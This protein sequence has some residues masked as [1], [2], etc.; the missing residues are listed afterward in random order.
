MTRSR[1]AGILRL[2]AVL[3]LVAALALSFG[4]TSDE[5][6]TLLLLDRSESVASDPAAV[7]RQQAWVRAAID[8]GRCGRPCRVIAFGGDAEFEGVDATAAAGRPGATTP[9]A[10]DRAPAAPDAAIPAPDATTPAP[11]ATDLAAALRLATGAL[12]DGGRAIV[13]SDGFA[14]DGD[15]P[16]A[17]ARAR[18]AKV[19]VDGVPLAGAAPGA[20][21]RPDAAVTRL[22]VP[23]PLRAG[24]ALTIQATVRSTVAGRATIRL[25]RDGAAAGSEPLT[26]R[27]GDNPLVLTYDAPPEGWHAYRLTVDLPGD[28]VPANDTAYATTR[29]APAPRAL[30]VGSAGALPT[31]LQNAGIAST[32]AAP[33]DINAATLAASDLVVLADLPARALSGAQQQALADAVRDDGLGLLVLGGEHSLSLGGWAGTPLDALLP[34]ASLR[35]GGVRR[36]RLALQLVLD[37]SSSMNDLAGGDQPKIAMAR[38]A[39]R[40][41]LRLTARDENELGIVTFDAAAR[42]LVP[43]Q[44]TTTANAG[45][46]GEL[47]DRLDAD[48]GTNVL[49]GLER[50]VAQLERSSAPVKHLLLLSDGVSE[51]ADYAPLLRRMRADRI[52]LSTVALGQDAD[53]ELMRRLARSAGGRF[54]A[55]PDAR[56]LPQVFAQEARRSAP[57][58]AARGELPVRETAA[59]PL[60]A[61]LQQGAT[62]PPVRGTVL[63]RLRPD[64]LA[65]LSA[66]VNGVTAPLLAQG[67]AGLGRVVVWTPGAGAWA[68]DWPATAPRLLP[69]AARWSAKPVATPPLT[70]LLDGDRLVVDPLA[71]SG[72]PLDL[73]TVTATVRAPDGSTRTLTLPQ[74][75]PS[76]YAA[77]LAA[78]GAASA[79]D[80]ATSAGDGTTSAG[81]SESSAE[82]GAASGEDAHPAP[83]VYAVATGDGSQA[84]DAYL[85]VQYAA[86]LAPQPADA[87]QLGELASAGGGSLLDPADP[88][89]ALA[90]DPG[91]PAWRWL[92][93]AAIALL[94]AAVAAPRLPR[95]AQARSRRR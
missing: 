24:D 82:D 11:D 37:R 71:T 61:S 10:T 6:P 26:L 30:I 53:A 21:A 51:P 42:D 92:V 15:A 88:H 85:P 7:A 12:P 66:T 89:T 56:R 34:V 65:P 67:Q 13:L 48:G 54:H 38:A 32:A 55:V 39:A 64:A 40:S 73:A 31:Q 58:V 16:A 86:E 3:A 90:P 36:R 33:Q 83:G 27:R 46:I 28:A 60:L 93:A 5:T 4:D 59:S 74:V 50:G 49:R 87:S 80:G 95:R 14:T 2:A 45:A 35:P 23:S 47:V 1:L 18:A 22:A 8:E 44:R 57:S 52:T 76:R 78:A 17:A 81:D 79:G 69:D 9:D 19:H 72:E 91:A 68:G 43:L 75:A 20:T 77:P 25:A 29:I 62:P 41:A 70:P 94:I 84:A 63:T